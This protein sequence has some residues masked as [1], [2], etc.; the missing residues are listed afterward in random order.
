MMKRL[1]DAAVTLDEIRKKYPE[2]S[3]E[4]TIEAHG[5]RVRAT[6]G[7]FSMDEFVLWLEMEQSRTNP[8]VRAIHTVRRVMTGSK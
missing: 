6:M 2:L 8:L 7:P 3:I 5:F 4:V 1:Q